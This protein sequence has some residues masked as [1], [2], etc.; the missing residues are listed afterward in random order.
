MKGDRGDL[1][2]YVY[3]KDKDGKNGCGTKPLNGGED[4]YNDRTNCEDCIFNN[5]DCP[6]E[7]I[8]E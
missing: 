7:L 8:N 4:H 6:K 2:D 3:E 1:R 5:H